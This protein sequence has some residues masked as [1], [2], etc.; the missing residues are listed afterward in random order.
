MSRR[1]P[2]AVT[3]EPYGDS[4][5]MISFDAPEA[6]LRRAAAARCHVALVANRPPV[7]TEIVAGLD[8]DGLIEA[9]HPDA[10][11]I[12]NVRCDLVIAYSL[13]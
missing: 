1:E 9:A 7:V 4:A 13:E 5:V 11:L 8:A 3:F 2:D 6:T 10:Q 12:D